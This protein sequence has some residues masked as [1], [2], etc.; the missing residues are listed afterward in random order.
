MVVQAALFLVA[1]K[2][3]LALVLVLPLALPLA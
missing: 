3:L 2:E 1:L